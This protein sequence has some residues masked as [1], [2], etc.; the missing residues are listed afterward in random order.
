MGSSIKDVTLL[1][2]GRGG[3]NVTKCDMGQG[4]YTI[5]LLN[6]TYSEKSVEYPLISAEAASKGPR[7]QKNS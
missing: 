2:E 4:E 7:E 1:G 3:K 5:L 6:S